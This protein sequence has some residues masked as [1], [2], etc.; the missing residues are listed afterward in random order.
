MTTTNPVTT[1]SNNA[2]NNPSGAAG[3]AATKTLAGNFQTF[4][5]LLTTQLQNQ[6][7]TSPMDS[8]QF[9]QQLVMYSQVEQQINT[10]DNLTKLI[11]LSQN[12]TTNLAMSYLGKKIVLSDGTGV[13]EGGSTKWTYGLNNIAKS[14]TLSVQDSNGKVVY[15]KLINTPADNTAGPHDFTWDGKDNYGN[16]LADGAYKMTVS[17][18]AA[19]GSVV[20]NT[21]ASNAGVAGVDLSGTDPQLVIGNAEV[22]LS[23]VSLITN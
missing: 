23:S 21:I 10:N 19:D 22:P 15:S 13:L 20:K 14:T 16:Q 11:S 17:A 4:L 3:N 6:D 9:T 18:V 7:P 8:N 5:T 2:A 12:Q 1:P